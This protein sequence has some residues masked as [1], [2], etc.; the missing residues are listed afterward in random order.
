MTKTKLTKK[1]KKENRRIDKLNRATNKLH[2]WLER[3]EERLVDLPPDAIELNSLPTIQLGK[4]LIAA[5]VRNISR[6]GTE[7]AVLPILLEQVME[8]LASSTMSQGLSMKKL[9]ERVKSDA[10]NTLSCCGVKKDQLTTQV[11]AS[12]S[13]TDNEEADEDDDEDPE[14]EEKL[15]DAMA[16]VR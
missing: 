4:M 7:L 3:H 1:Q 10:D 2:K 6:A 12:D 16:A 5:G 15:K 14:S 11:P 9:L 13:P 8:M